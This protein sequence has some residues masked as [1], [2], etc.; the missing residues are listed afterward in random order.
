MVVHEQTHHNFI[1]GSG[2][3]TSYWTAASLKAR[4][5]AC[6][7]DQTCTVVASRSNSDLLERRIRRIV[8]QW[9]QEELER[10]Y[11]EIDNASELNAYGE[12]DKIS[13]R[14]LYQEKCRPK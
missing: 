8:D 13:P 12:S 6:T 14:Y 7:R 4:L 5:E 11:R 3:G 1:Y 10:W 9:S 2:P